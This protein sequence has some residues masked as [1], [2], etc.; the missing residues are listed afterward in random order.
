[1]MSLEFYTLLDPAE[2]EE[3]AAE[4]NA[5]ADEEGNGCRFIVR[6]DPTGRGQSFI[7]EHDEIGF[8]GRL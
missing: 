8:V 3:I 6:H 4:L 2:A 5:E 1:M 7:E